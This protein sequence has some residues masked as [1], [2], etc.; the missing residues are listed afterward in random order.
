MK[1]T[2]VVLFAACLATS[3]SARQPGVRQQVSTPAPP[4]PAAAAAPAL[5]DGV[6]LVEAAERQPGDDVFI[7]YRSTA[8]TTA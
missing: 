1:R 8:S 5:P 7:P 4:V 2:M 3:I 6:T